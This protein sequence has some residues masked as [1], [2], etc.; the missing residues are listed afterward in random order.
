LRH[1]FKHLDK[2]KLDLITHSATGTVNRAFRLPV[3]ASVCLSEDLLLLWTFSDYRGLHSLGDFLTDPVRAGPLFIE[4]DI[5]YSQLAELWMD[6]HER[7]P[8]K[9]NLYGHIFFCHI[10]SRLIV[11][12]LCSAWNNGTIENQPQNGLFPFLAVPLIPGCFV[13]YNIFNSIFRSMSIHPQQSLS[14]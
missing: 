12:H 7:S 9:G 13:G 5:Y 1:S 2:P 14:E 4:Q 6:A 3:C 10:L 8:E 11:S